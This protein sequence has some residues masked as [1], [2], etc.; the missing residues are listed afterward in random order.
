MTW[1]WGVLAAGGVGFI[2]AQQPVINGATGTAL[3]SPLV[4]AAMSLSLSA[5]IVIAVCLITG[6]PLSADRIMALPWWAF[7]GGV[8]GAI[9]VT[10]GATLVPITGAALF[11]VCLIAGQL[12][13]S[14]VADTVGAFGLEPRPLS[15]RKLAGIALAFS[16][17]VLV[18]WG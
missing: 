7:L 18:R 8:I 9:F 6:A 4:A 3:G 13:G 15:L 5:V 2:L 12:V 10:G 11:F 16:G 17:V 1:L 14:V